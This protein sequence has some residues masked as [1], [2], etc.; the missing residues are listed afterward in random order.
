MM[1][2]SKFLLG[3]FFWTYFSINAQSLD[4]SFGTN[5]KVI[6]TFSQNYTAQHQS[7][8]MQSDGKILNVGYAY[9]GNYL[10]K[11][12]VTRHLSDGVLDATFDT[13]GALEFTYGQN[14]EEANSIIQLSNGKIAV[15]GASFGN[16]VV[17]MLNDNGTFDSSFGTNGKKFLTIGQGNGSKIEK[18]IQQPDGKILTFGRGSNGNDFDFMITRLHLDGTFDTSFGTNGIVLVPISSFHDFATDAAFQSNGKFVVAGYSTGSQDSISVIRLNANG[19]LDTTFATNGKYNTAFGSSMNEIW[20][21][22]IQ[23]DDRI[24]LA[25]RVSG[26]SY[27]S[28]ETLTV[29][30]TSN[31]QLD[32]SFNST[33]FAAVDFKLNAQDAV[34]DVLLLP[35]GSILI[36]G[37]SNQD[38]EFAMLQFSPNGSINTNFGNNGRFFVSVGNGQVAWINEGLLLPNNDLLVGGLV[39]PEVGG[40]GQFGMVKLTDLNLSATDFYATNHQISIYP[41]PFSAIINIDFASD[42]NFKKAQ[43]VSLIGQQVIKEIDLSKNNAVDVSSLPSGVYLIVLFYDEHKFS[44]KIVKN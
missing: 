34:N 31:G 9:E 36:M 4:N 16:A 18:L 32:T 6:H 37:S 8:F 5:G 40:K 28:I 10:A 35:N 41:N 2:N 7:Y 21:I 12:L 39:V 11:I 27:N 1:V 15:G 20:G 26:S 19:S 38:S 14:F 44:Y 43:I 23:T 30:L 17:A 25:G 33:G 13:D 29:R 24:V 3:F 22:A 42:F